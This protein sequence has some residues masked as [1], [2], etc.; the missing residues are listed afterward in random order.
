MGILNKSILLYIFIRNAIFII[1]RDDFTLMRMLSVAPY[2]SHNIFPQFL[3]LL[4]HIHVKVF[5]H[6]WWG[7]KIL[8]SHAVCCHCRRDADVLFCHSHA[9]I[10]LLDL[11]AATLMNSQKKNS[12]MTNDVNHFLAH[13][14]VKKIFLL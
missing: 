14:I 2:L 13:A 8:Q 4:I 1:M 11:Q 3:K 9:I 10:S 12:Q 6:L 7:E 5:H